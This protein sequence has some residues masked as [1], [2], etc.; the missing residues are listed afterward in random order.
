MALVVQIFFEQG[1]TGW[2]ET[3]YTN[4]D[5]E[6]D[7]PFAGLRA[8]IAFGRGRLLS[9]GVVLSAIR[10][11]DLNNR[12]KVAVFQ[13]PGGS[14][15]SFPTIPTTADPDMPFTS[16]LV[17]YNMAA[18]G[19]R[20]TFMR[21]LQDGL[22]H[23]KDGKITDATWLANFNAWVNYQVANGFIG[24]VRSTGQ[25]PKPITDFTIV[26]GKYHIFADTSILP[27]DQKIR[28]S[29]FVSDPPIN[30]VWRAHSPDTGEIILTESNTTRTN[31]PR[32]NPGGVYRTLRSE[33]SAIVSGEQVRFTSHRVGRPF[34]L[35]RSRRRRSKPAF[36]FQLT[37]Q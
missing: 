25:G 2:S 19:I 10:I 4:G 23:S 32:F 29:G 20:R 3:Y 37:A 16:V 11:S 18:G 22:T 12:K 7:A 8:G 27:S 31:P 28:I 26:S 34:G 1:R 9:E 5:F 21:G 15:F 17:R 24:F 33:S 6:G 13:G 30:G 36:P 35:L 14:P